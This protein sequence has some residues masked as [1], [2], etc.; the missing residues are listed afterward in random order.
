MPNAVQSTNGKIEWVYSSRVRPPPYGYCTPIKDVRVDVDDGNMLF[1]S[2]SLIDDPTLKALFA[3]LWNLGVSSANVI[4]LHG[5]AECHV[6][7]I[8]NLKQRVDGL[9]QHSHSFPP[10]IAFEKLPS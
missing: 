9:M 7:R 1:V 4:S 8:S 10:V 6:I 2:R 3:T 5:M